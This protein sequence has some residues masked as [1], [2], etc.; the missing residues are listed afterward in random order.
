MARAGTRRHSVGGFGLAAAVVVALVSAGPA[1]ADE[2]EGLVPEGDWTD[3]QIAYMLDKIEETEQVLPATFPELAT[4]EELEAELGA[5]GFFEFGA[6]AP[7]GYDHWIN[8]SWFFDDHLIDPEFAESL[9]YQ[10]QPDGRWKLV[11]AMFMLDP[12]I[13]MSEI[14]E[15]I[16]WLPGW[17]GHP[18]LCV[19]ADGPIGT[20]AGITDPDNP[21]C[22]AGTRQ[23]TTPVMMHVWIV[24]NACNHRF[25]GIGVS[26]LHCEHGGH[27]DGGHDDGGHG[28]GGH[29][30][31]GH[32]DGG[33][34]EGD[35]H[36]PGDDGAGD[37]EVVI[38][39]EAQPAVPVVAE[40]S[41][42]G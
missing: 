24:D 13:D 17:H 10:V 41:F 37:H 16:A 8:P 29:D 3:D 27:G 39:L 42:T 35:G 20:F 22:P 26:G 28:D 7:G 23:A 25:G 36:E 4:Y 32:G 1:S 31:G 14:P 2:H 18:E 21:D 15:D 11:S 30:D 19:N 9:V 5:L 38:E 6:T 12:A 40:P 34:E 33:H